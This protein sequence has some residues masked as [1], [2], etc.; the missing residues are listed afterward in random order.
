[1]YVLFYSIDRLSIAA[2]SNG[3][4]VLATSLSMIVLN[5][6][7]AIVDIVN[8]SIAS[9]TQETDQPEGPILDDRD[10]NGWVT[11]IINHLFKEIMT[12]TDSTVFAVFLCWFFV[13]LVLINL[14]L[15]NDHHSTSSDGFSAWNSTQPT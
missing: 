14:I 12:P 9:T 7:E 4:P 6:E 11:L 3:S 1:M 8:N 2:A 5:S 15:V 13:F 10:V